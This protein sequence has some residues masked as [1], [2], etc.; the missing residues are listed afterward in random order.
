MP[1]DEKSGG[2]FVMLPWVISFSENAVSVTSIGQ[3]Y[4]AYV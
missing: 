3:A 2:I 1:S 4:Y